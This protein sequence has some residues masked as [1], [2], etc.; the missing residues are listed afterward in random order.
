MGIL[1]DTGYRNPS[2]NDSLTGGI[3]CHFA[4]YSPAIL[5]PTFCIICV[6]FGTRF[7]YS[8]FPEPGNGAVTTE[9]AI[10]QLRSRRLMSRIEVGRIYGDLLCTRPLVLHI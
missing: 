8:F 3:F 4:Y 9:D 6:L 1:Q 2:F 5:L 7:D 10:A